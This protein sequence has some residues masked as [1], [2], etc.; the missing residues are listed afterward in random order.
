M[1]KKVKIS[2]K[3]ANLLKRVSPDLL[4]WGDDSP[5]SKE[6]LIK[7]FVLLFEEDME[8][9][10]E[11]EGYYVIQHKVQGYRV[12]NIFAARNTPWAVVLK[13]R[14]ISAFLQK[15]KFDTGIYLAC[16][17]HHL[18]W[19]SPISPIYKKVRRAYFMGVEKFDIWLRKNGPLAP[20]YKKYV[21]ERRIKKL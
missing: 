21:Y 4:K 3:L 18:L 11:P 13:V 20:L 2:K 8:E 10:D 12:E 6:E 16:Q 19:Y 9:W 1:Q 15:V 14:G 5:I 7:F 17:I